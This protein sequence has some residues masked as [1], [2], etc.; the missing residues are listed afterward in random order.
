MNPSGGRRHAPAAPRAHMLFDLVR[1]RRRGAA[2]PRG[3]SDYEIMFRG[4]SLP[5]GVRVGFVVNDV[6]RPVTYWDKAPSSLELT[7][8]T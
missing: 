7:W 2:V 1:V 6:G 5:A 8:S 4:S 3:I